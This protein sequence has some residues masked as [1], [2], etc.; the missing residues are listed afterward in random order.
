[1]TQASQQKFDQRS[2]HSAVVAISKKKMSLRFSSTCDVNVSVLKAEAQ[3]ALI[4]TFSLEV[5]KTSVCPCELIWVVWGGKIVEKKMSR[6][7]TAQ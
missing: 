3:N 5:A 1:M 2:G 4:L 7:L 6:L